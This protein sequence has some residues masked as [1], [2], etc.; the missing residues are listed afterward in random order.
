MSQPVRQ[1]GQSPGPPRVLGDH[2]DAAEDGLP[3]N[4]P[5]RLDGIH[6]A[7]R[8]AGP[9]IDAID[10][11]RPA[12]DLPPPSSCSRSTSEVRA[13][14]TA[15]TSDGASRA[16][17]S[18]GNLPS[19]SGGPARISAIAQRRVISPGCSCSSWSAGSATGRARGGEELED[20]WGIHLE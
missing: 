4:A 2:S 1:I 3:E 9:V 12:E 16:R 5:E 20:R 13:A 10:V 11:A 15:L 8:V 17:S 19:D 6:H 7:R 14:S 18:S